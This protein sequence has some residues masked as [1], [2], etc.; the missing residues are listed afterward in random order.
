[1]I[2]I[3]EVTDRGMLWEKEY[4]RIGQA[5]A[6]LKIDPQALRRWTKKGFVKHILAPTGKFIYK[7]SDIA[8]FAKK[9]ATEGAPYEKK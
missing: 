4:L 1:M 5:A 7:T 9:L 8:E 3:M 6:L 2:G